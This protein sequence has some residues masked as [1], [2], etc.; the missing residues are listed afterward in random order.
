[1]PFIYPIIEAN[2]IEEE[3]K[4]LAEIFGSK[5]IICSSESE[6]HY[7]ISTYKDLGEEQKNKFLAKYELPVNSSKNSDN[8]ILSS[9]FSKIFRIEKSVG[10]ITQNSVIAKGSYSYSKSSRAP[11]V[12]S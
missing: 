8:Y 11:P 6:K 3:Y 1:M 12:L 7:F 4:K 5:A 2:H 9:G 10:F